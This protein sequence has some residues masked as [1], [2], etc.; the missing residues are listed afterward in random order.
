[1]ILFALAT[2]WLIGI[3]AAA[4][5]LTPLWPLLTMAGLG[6]C[7][8]FVIARDRRRALWVAACLA[9]ALVAVLRYEGE[10]PPANPGG[11]AAF[12]EGAA[13]TLRGEITDEPEQRERSQRFT[14]R[15][16]AYEDGDGWV[17]IEGSVLVTARPFPRFEYGDKLELQA[18][19]ETPP[20]D[21]GFDYREYL[22]RQGVVSLALFPQ[23]E[24]SGS[25]G[26]DFLRRALIEARRPFDDALVRSL[27]EPEASLA[28]GILLGQRASIPASVT[29]DFNRAGISHLI[30]ISGW[31]VTLI[32]GF[33]VSLL[34]WPLGRRQA[35]VAAMALIL[36]YAAFVGGGPAVW[37]AALMGEVMLGAV[38]VGRPGS[39]L[40]AVT[41]AGALLTLFNPL[42]IQ[43]VSFQ[44]SFCATLG[45]VISEKRA[46][47]TL[48]G[49]ASWLPN[50]LTQSLAVTIA[51]SIAV[52]P[53]IALHF[54]RVSFV[55]LLSNLVAVPAFPFVI[56]ASFIT[57][58]AGAVSA[59]LGRLIGEVAY[60]PLAYLVWL[61][62]VGSSLPGASVSVASLSV[63]D[64]FTVLGVLAA[65]AFTLRHLPRGERAEPSR[66]PR[67]R[68]T[69]AA[70]GVLGLMAVFAWSQTLS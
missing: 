32:A 67:L 54:G 66:S 15:V 7:L 10:K 17:A 30:A 68:W 21:A 45:L 56:A 31:N 20:D 46:E 18:R 39:A 64:G 53:L 19:L 41:L 12:N 16:D 49:L 35:V 14:V 57:A 62:R 60:L 65:G 22:A 23:I 40:T 47:E 8:G 58:L 33:A 28:R 69:L 38:L 42:T 50:V 63:I 25:D 59:E 61:A 44:L 37:R 52:M 9:L 70:A 43:D 11:I 4:L 6:A 13:V 51:A 26:G 36:L 1:M 3:A 5:D 27:P 48:Q 29:D 2:A 55:A 24:R 34:R